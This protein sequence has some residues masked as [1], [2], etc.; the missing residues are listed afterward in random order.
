MASAAE[1]RSPGLNFNIFCKKL[2]IR[3]FS[4]KP[5]NGILFLKKNV[6]GCVKNTLRF[7]KAK[8]SSISFFGV[9]TNALI[10]TLF[11]KFRK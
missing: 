2:K 1:I 10:Y 6:G 7:W 3:V 8:S 9:E 5:M 4:C 11:A